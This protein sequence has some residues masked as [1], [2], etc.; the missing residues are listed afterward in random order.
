MGFTEQHWFDDEEP[1]LTEWQFEKRIDDLEKEYKKG[2]EKG[3]AAG[4]KDGSE[5]AMADM[6]GE[7]DGE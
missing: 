2:Y 4:Y 5:K 7:Q 3:Y 6:R 1:E